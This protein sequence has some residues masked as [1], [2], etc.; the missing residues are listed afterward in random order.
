MTEKIKEYAERAIG[1]SIR[2]NGY[3]CQKCKITIY[4]IDRDEGVTPFMIP[5][6]SNIKKLSSLVHYP[7]NRRRNCN[8]DMYSHFYN[9]AP[10]NVPTFEWFK[11]NPNQR[12][13][14]GIKIYNE[15]MKDH[16]KNGG[17]DLRKIIYKTRINNLSIR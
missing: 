10:K 17:L 9:V 6:L 1:N 12:N 16:F 8:G 3:T 14:L 15:V 5:C 11:P 7:H 2:I 13:L 4:T